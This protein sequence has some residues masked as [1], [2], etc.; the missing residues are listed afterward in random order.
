MLLGTFSLMND[1]ITE[2]LGSEQRCAFLSGPSFALEIM[3]NQATAVVIASLDDVLANE[4]SYIL[5]S[6]EFRCHTSHDVMVYIF[7]LYLYIYFNIILE[8][9]YI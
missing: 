6:N 1:I 7:I 5:S 4:L 9:L 2:S 3:N 8:L